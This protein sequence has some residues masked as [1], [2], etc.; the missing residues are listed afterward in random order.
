MDPYRLAIFVVYGL[1]SHSLAAHLHS[2]WLHGRGIISYTA[3]YAAVMG[4]TVF[5]GFTIFSPRELVG[6]S[7]NAWVVSLPLGVV[8]GV[9]AGWSDRAIVRSLSRRRFVD[10]MGGQ[11]IVRRTGQRSHRVRRVTHFPVAG[12]LARRRALGLPGAQ[13]TM[14]PSAGDRPFGLLPLLV[15]ATLEELIYR[16]L[17]VQAALLLPSD[18]M[19]ALALA[20]SVIS[21]ALS[22]IS[23]GWPHV[24]AK[25][26]LSALALIAVISLGTVLPAI[27]AH[28]VFNARI[29]RDWRSQ[30]RFLGSA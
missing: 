29:W 30:P 25:L 12:Q 28:L 21:F 20:G 24:A 10:E 2:R 17:L 8:I 1:S 15:V 16:G 4:F 19:V 13:Q 11:P 26:P 23:F 22:H 5:W 14:W 9:I 6:D 18:F 3:A 7:V 27:L